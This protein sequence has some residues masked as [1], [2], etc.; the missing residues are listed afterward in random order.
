MSLKKLSKLLKKT[1]YAVRKKFKSVINKA[2]PCMS[3]P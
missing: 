1:L 2:V 3:Y